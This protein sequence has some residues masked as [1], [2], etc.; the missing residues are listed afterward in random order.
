MGKLW[1]FNGL[2]GVMTGVTNNEVGNIMKTIWDSTHKS[3]ETPKGV[4]ETS[5]DLI[6]GHAKVRK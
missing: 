5:Q 6:T 1:D 2:V 4:K 3:K